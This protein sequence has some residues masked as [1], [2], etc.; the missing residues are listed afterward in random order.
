LMP[1]SSALHAWV[2]QHPFSA[3]IVVTALCWPVCGCTT[4]ILSGVASVAILC[5][6]S[7]YST[8]SANAARSL[9]AS[10][11][12]SII[13]G[14]R[15]LIARIPTSAPI[16]AE[17]CY[18]CDTSWQRSFI[19]MTDVVVAGQPQWFCI[20]VRDAV[21]STTTTTM[22]SKLLHDRTRIKRPRDA[23]ASF[24]STR[25]RSLIIDCALCTTE[26]ERVGQGARATGWLG[27]IGD[28]QRR[29]SSDHRR[30]TLHRR[31]YLSMRV[32]DS[33][34]QRLLGLDQA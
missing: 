1:P 28:R 16:R 25:D 11:S 2:L 9:A 15:R 18:I 32:P 22:Q 13:D 30:R 33:Q 31:R 12:A 7:N 27:C 8:P 19:G 24:A 3:S 5:C 29:C 10:S 26:Y 6:L 34:G 17:S 4:A 20:Q 23:C 21:P 14:S